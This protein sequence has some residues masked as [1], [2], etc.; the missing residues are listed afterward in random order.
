M[1]NFCSNIVVVYNNVDYETDMKN[2]TKRNNNAANLI[3]VLARR[4][5]SP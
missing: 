4:K 3:C 2:N 5:T 1:R